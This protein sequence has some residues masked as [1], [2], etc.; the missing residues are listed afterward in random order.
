MAASAADVL[1]VG[2]SP[3]GCA[4][5]IAAARRGRSVTLLEPT[6]VLGGLSANGVHAFD[7][8]TMQS[9]SGLAEE[10]AAAIRAY[11]KASGLVDPLL[12]SP[13]DLF[14]ES[15]VAARVWAG[16]VAA[17]PNIRV[18]L[19]AVPVAV[20]VADGRIAA[21]L[22]EDAVDG[23]GN[24]GPRGAPQHRA[25]GGVVIDATYEGDIAAWAGV[26][27]DLGREAWSPEEPHAGEIYTTT[28]AYDIRHGALPSTILPGSSGAGDDRLMA[29]GCRLTLR[30]YDDPS[31]DAAHRLKS[32]PPGYDPARYSWAES[33]YFPEGR[34][35]F[36]TGIIPGV[37]GKAL[38]NRPFEGSDHVGDNRAYILADPRERPAIRQRFMDH[39]LG[40][41]YFIQTE[42]GS[43]RIGLATDEFIDNDH[44]NHML[45]IREGRRIRGRARVTESDIHPFLA[46]DGPR[47]PLKPDAIAIGDW[48]IE[49]KRVR[50]EPSPDYPHYDGSMFCRAVRAPYQIPYGC[51]LPQQIDNLLVTMAVSATHVAYSAIRVESVWIQTGTA[52]GIAAA[53][54][55]ETGAAPAEV[56]VAA[57]QEGQIGHGNKL[58]YFRDVE[59]AHPQFAAIHWAALRG[60]VPDDPNYRFFPGRAATWPK[61]LEATVRCLRL[62]ISVTGFH[63]EGL[64]PGNPA[65]RYAETLYDLGSR[66]GVSI[67]PNMIDPVI[68]GPADYLRGEPR[69]RW[70]A[71]DLHSPVDRRDTAGFLARTA[72]ALAALGRPVAGK[73]PQHGNGPLDRATLCQWLRDMVAA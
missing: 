1:V 25:T 40:F 62:P 35:R 17:E 5:A 26:P 10:F 58:T 32:P 6:P 72:Q 44:L 22:W 28:H 27:F 8:G 61:L 19:R 64:N 3:A 47:A 14:W 2:G 73:L 68:D 11:Y 31:P 67:F 34:A 16:M 59:T 42:G 51:L 18:V 29:F 66:A 21:V 63:F 13:T 33:T 69:T 45:Y 36:G 52:A 55:V 56:P 71:L 20:E 41:L 50:D 15:H 9:I 24:A 53:L 39:M 37:N 57:V 30:F 49:I 54:A 43:P 38:T 12:D 65:L 60:V 48:P 4:A 23:Y 70:L 7:T 46:G